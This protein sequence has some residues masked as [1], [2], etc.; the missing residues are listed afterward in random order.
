MDNYYKSIE[1]SKKL[2]DLKTHSTVTLRVN[3]KGNPKHL[4]S[5]KLKK[6]NHVWAKRNRIY[7]SKRVDKRPVNMITT[8]YHP[9][10]VEITNSRGQP[11]TQPREVV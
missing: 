7:V 1:L 4:L 2:L 5:K 9:E 3:R 8:E 11:K 6:L 10:L